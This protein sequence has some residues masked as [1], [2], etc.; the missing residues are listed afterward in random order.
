MIKPI[1]TGVKK[2]FAALALLSLE[3]IVVLIMFVIAFFVFIQVARMVFLSDK[4]EIDKAAFNFLGE[5]IS[6]MNSNVMQF[7][8]FLGTHTFL[9]PANIILISYFLFIRKHRWYSIKIPVVS[10]SS[11]LL[12]YILKNFFQRPR[13][14]SPLLKE[15]KGLSFPSGHALNSVAFYGLL[16]YLVWRNV[17]NA[18]L[19][20]LLITGLCVIIFMIGLSRVY[21]RVHYISDVLAGYAVGFMWLILSIWLLKKMENYSRKKVTPVIEKPGQIARQP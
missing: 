13:P 5:H 16:I 10:I 17:K 21:L 6:D 2:F 8:T 9:I 14:L 4:R 3:V 20:W 11:V 18:K 1:R 7:F 12:M 19:R 15:A